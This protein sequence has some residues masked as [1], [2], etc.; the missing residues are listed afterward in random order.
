M[1]QDPD[2]RMLGLPLAQGRRVQI[3]IGG[4]TALFSERLVFPLLPDY[5][6]SA[7]STLNSDRA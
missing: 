4:A 7:A 2:L 3:S 6:W 5:G 1:S